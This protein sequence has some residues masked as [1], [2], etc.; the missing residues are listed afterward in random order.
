M[1]AFPAIRMGQA[2][3]DTEGM[4]LRDYFAAMAMQGMMDGNLYPSAI[5]AIAV[6]AYQM[7]DQMMEIRNDS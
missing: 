6:V 1:K 5:K 3:P 7:A 2:S 4:D